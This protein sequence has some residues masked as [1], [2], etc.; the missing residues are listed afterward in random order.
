MMAG[1]AMQGGNPMEVLTG[2]MQSKLAQQQYAG[3]TPMQMGEREK[4][5]YEMISSLPDN[6]NKNTEAY[7]KTVTAMQSMMTPAEKAGLMV[8]IKPTWMQA[9]QVALGGKQMGGKQ[10]GGVTGKAGTALQTKIDAITQMMGGQGAGSGEELSG[11]M[12][13]LQ[14]AGYTIKKVK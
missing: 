4:M 6:V 1:R 10:V 8:G 9:A 7:T 2:L 13:A 12:Q 11:H 3:Q 5:A 14:K